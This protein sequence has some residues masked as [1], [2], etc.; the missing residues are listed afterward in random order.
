MPVYRID[1]TTT[2]Y[3]WTEHGPPTTKQQREWV[4][5]EL[6]EGGDGLAVDCEEVT[7]ATSVPLEWRVAYPWC[8]GPGP[9]KTIRTLL[10]GK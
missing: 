9:Q 8:D 10:E 1:A 7:D 4:R 3:C 6:R 5:D 2:V